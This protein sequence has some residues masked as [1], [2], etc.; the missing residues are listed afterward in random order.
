MKD[1]ILLAVCVVAAVGLAAC[2]K[3]EEPTEEPAEKETSA[4]EESRT[5]VVEE[6]AAAGEDRA[7]AAAAEEAVADT[8]EP[9]SEAVEFETAIVDEEVVEPVMGRLRHP[10]EMNLPPDVEVAAPDD[11]E[12]IMGDVKE[13]LELNEL[14]LAE[15]LLDEL[16]MMKPSL[17]DPMQAQIEELEA[18]VY[19]AREAQAGGSLRYPRGQ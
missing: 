7:A 4:V 1:R 14:S 17:S 3:S 2:G 13:M 6:R 8:P 11:P 16:Y 10:D 12:R 9:V 15:E 19:S 5:I 18:M